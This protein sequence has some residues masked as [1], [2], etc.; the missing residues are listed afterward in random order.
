MVNSRRS[1][2]V[3]SSESLCGGAPPSALST[4][5]SCGSNSARRGNCKPIAV[6]ICKTTHVQLQ[7]ASAVAIATR[8]SS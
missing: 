5:P 2:F 7:I 1:S 4:R 6:A 8:N 3:A